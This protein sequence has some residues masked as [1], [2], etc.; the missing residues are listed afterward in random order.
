MV[1]LS[2]PS[3]RI[4][5]WMDACNLSCRI[6]LLTQLQCTVQMYSQKRDGHVRDASYVYAT[7]TLPYIRRISHKEGVALCVCLCGSCLIIQ[8]LGNLLGV[9]VSVFNTLPQRH[10]SHVVASKENATISDTCK[11]LLC[12]LRCRSPHHLTL[13]WAHLGPKLQ[14][15]L[16]RTCTHS[17]HSPSLAGKRQQHMTGTCLR[18]LTSPYVEVLLAIDCVADGTV[19]QGV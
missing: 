5:R 14:A 19:E 15:L 10:A 16:H 2:R 4:C 12:T 3:L 6:V 18:S 1:L 13:H 8:I 7:Q 11:I 9:L 17:S